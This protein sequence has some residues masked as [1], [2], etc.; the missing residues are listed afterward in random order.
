MPGS[1]PDSQW[2]EACGADDINRLVTIA[3]HSGV[4]VLVWGLFL[5]V[6]LCVVL[7][8]LA[9]PAVADD[10][11]PWFGNDGQKP[12]KVTD[13]GTEEFSIAGQRPELAEAGNCKLEDCSENTISGISLKIGQASP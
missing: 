5:I 9:V 6:R 10:A 4:G 3:R 8:F 13:D 12:F 7:V 1:L 11:S 2:L